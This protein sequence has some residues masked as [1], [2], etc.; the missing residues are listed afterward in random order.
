MTT[1]QQQKF[2]TTKELKTLRDMVCR[3]YPT[4]EIARSLQRPVDSVRHARRVHCNGLVSTESKARDR[5]RIKSEVIRLREE[6]K[7]CHEIAKTLALKE[8][9]VRKWIIRW[10]LPRIPRDA[11]SWKERLSRSRK[12]MFAARNPKPEPC[13]SEPAVR[14]KGDLAV[15]QHVWIDAGPYGWKRVIVARDKRIETEGKYGINTSRDEK[16]LIVVR[17]RAKLLTDEE[18]VAKFKL[19]QLPASGRYHPQRLLEHE[20]ARDENGSGNA[21]GDQ[22]LA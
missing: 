21:R 6:N 12:A 18:M 5:A 17:A 22:A 10:K 8:G 1:K 14:Q 13:K 2:W 16:P 3:G 20:R 7:T 19:Q 9:T 4:A 15:G 11:F